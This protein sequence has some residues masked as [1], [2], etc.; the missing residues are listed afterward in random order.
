[1]TLE[2]LHLSDDP[3]GDRIIEAAAQ[4]FIKQGFEGASTLAIAQDAKTS[5]REIYDRFTSKEELFESVMAYVCSLYPGNGNP[6]SND[7]L[8]IV[9]STGKNVL[10]HFLLPETRG[11][12][13]AALSASGKFPNVTS[14]FWNAVP[15]QAIKTLSGLFVGSPQIAINTEAEAK[16]A[17]HRF[18]LDCCGPFTLALLFDKS[19]KPSQEDIDAHIN[20]VTQNFLKVYFRP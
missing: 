19:A 5:K 6:A 2:T 20:L 18:I 1:M 17:A 8:S 16:R 4:R 14:I 12:L 10:H 13:I 15:G 3:I 11:V 9:T 7:M